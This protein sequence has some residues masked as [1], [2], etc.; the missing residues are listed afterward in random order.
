MSRSP[1]YHIVVMY[2]QHYIYMHD[3]LLNPIYWY[4]FELTVW[5]IHNWYELCRQITQFWIIQ[6]YSVCAFCTTA[7][8]VNLIW[9]WPQYSAYYALM[10]CT[11]SYVYLVQ[12]SILTIC[13]IMWPVIRHMSVMNFAL[14]I[15]ENVFVFVNILKVIN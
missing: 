14:S 15:I 1:Y 11:G 10:H 13:I 9:H 6:I 8:L 4:L 12:P 2:L 3:I 5:V 7:I